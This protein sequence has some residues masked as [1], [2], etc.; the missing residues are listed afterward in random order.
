MLDIIL[1][2]VTL[3]HTSKRYW[4]RP[5]S[6]PSSP[7]PKS[8]LS[9]WPTQRG[10]GSRPFTLPPR[11]CS[12]ALRGKRERS[13]VRRAAGCR[14]GVSCQTH[15]VNGLVSEQIVNLAH[16][17]KATLIIVGHRHLTWIQ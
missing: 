15:A 10:K 9:P 12:K 7:E 17:V 6:W 16:D 14:P 5:P 11:D 13:F 3:P 1:V 2:A 8:M 4:T